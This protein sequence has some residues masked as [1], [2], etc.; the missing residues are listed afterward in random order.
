MRKR[1]SVW[2]EVTARWDDI[3]ESAGLGYVPRLPASG[4]LLGSS[5]KVAK[6]PAVFVVR[7]IYMAPAQEAFSVIGDKRTL[8]GKASA[9]CA[10]L[11]LGHS[12]GHLQWD[13]ARNARGWKTALLLGDRKLWRELLDAEIRNHDASCRASG[14]IAVVRVDGSS[15]TGEGKRSALRHP[16]VQHYD[17]TK[18]LGA[19]LGSQPANYSLVFSWSGENVAECERALAAGCNVAVPFDTPKGSPMPDAFMGS[20]IVDGD[21]DDLRFLDPQGDRG[22][23]IGLRFKAGQN[24]QGGIDRSEGFV[25][26]V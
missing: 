5:T 7:V 20:E 22:F 26:R 8:C 25:V 19:A 10:A 24:R 4:H 16:T 18:R 11:C 12:T 13:H 1:A 15:D 6:G 21:A 14:K 9:A 17:Y 23:V 3:C 2:R